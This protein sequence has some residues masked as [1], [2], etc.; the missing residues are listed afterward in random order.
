MEISP[1]QS[2]FS[3]ITDNIFTLIYLFAIAEVVIIGVIVVSMR[4]HSLR[5]QDVSSNLVKGFTDA[6][7]ND[8]LQKPHEK[9]DG[10]LHYLSN[11]ILL[12]DDAANIIEK[13]VSRLT[14]RSLFNR[15]YLI[16]SAISVMSTLVQVF[17]LLGILGTILAIA[18]TAFGDGGIDASRLTEAFV[19]AMDTT[20]LG[21]SLSVVFMVIESILSPK[22]ERIINESIDF[23]NIITKVRLG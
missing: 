19:L 13:N 7:D 14:E 9:I 16:E 22:V 5:L 10:A 2:L 3:V 8:S 21:I 1:I 17:P 11:K 23:K 20:I 15:Y 4:R 18:G 6:P 12:D